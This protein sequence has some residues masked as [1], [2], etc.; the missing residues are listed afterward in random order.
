[1]CVVPTDKTNSK[2]LL[3]TPFYSN[4]VTTYL[5][6]DYSPTTLE[7]QLEVKEGTPQKLE[8]FSNILSENKYN[9]LKSNINIYNAPTVQILVQL[10]KNPD[11][12]GEFP[13]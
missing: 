13:T 4:C 8:N 3:K 10:H 5:S 7:Y 12:N 2:G 11:E 9:Y 1:M 6:E